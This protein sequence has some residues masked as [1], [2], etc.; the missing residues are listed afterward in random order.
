[1][2]ASHSGSEDSR[3]GTE[4][5][6]R[7]S[8]LSSVR[9]ESAYLLEFAQSLIEQSLRE[10]EVV[11]VDDGST[12]GTPELISELK[13][14]DPR[15]RLVGSG[16]HVGKAAAFSV[17]YENSRAPIVCLA[18]GDDRLP[19]DSLKTRV[20]LMADARPGSPVAAYGKLRTFSDDPKFDGLLLP[21]GSASSRSGGS[22]TF[23]RALGD[24]LFPIPAELPS[25]DTWLQFVA[26]NRSER[27]V[28]SSEVFLEYRIHDENSH[29][30]Q[31]SF[32]EFTVGMAK[33][34]RVWIS[35][36]EE[37]RLELSAEE[38][39]EVEQYIARED[40]R[41]NGRIFKIMT[42]RNFRLVDR[43]AVAS[44]ANPYLYRVRTKFY[45]TFTGMRSA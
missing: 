44:M 33:R 19:P 41:A 43:L 25:E 4:N 3:D 36:A 6:C 40:D 22:I 26:K 2:N 21:K 17:A 16:E 32:E 29:P 35:L 31:R 30:R 8:V 18:A 20:A 45:R 13:A 14:R 37:Q 10:W 15:F 7:I 5:A 27:E 23:N 12:D 11:F 1:M 42:D 38:R 34:N 9:N 39:S 24:V 28:H